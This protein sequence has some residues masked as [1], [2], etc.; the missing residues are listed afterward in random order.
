MSVRTTRR[1]AIL[2]GALA[3]GL[4]ALAPAL[5]AAAATLSASNSAGAAL[6]VESPAITNV[7]GVATVTGTA[8]VTVSV[9]GDGFDGGY[10][11]LWA[12]YDVG[13][14]ATYGPKPTGFKLQRGLFSEAHTLWIS[15][16]GDP[17]DGAQPFNV[18][19]N[20]AFDYSLDIAPTYV[21][22]D[23][24]TVDCTVTQCYIHTFTAHGA[25]LTGTQN[26]VA[27]PVDWN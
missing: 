22:D 9:S 7:G 5:P 16:G 21:N 12:N 8:P 13:I 19:A 3:A 11:A 27:I 15:D 25:N 10:R 1:T 14:Y 2:G 4:L 18:T 17:A 26:D 23:G 24:D 20:E 6:T